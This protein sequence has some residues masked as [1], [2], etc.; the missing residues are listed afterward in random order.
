MGVEIRVVAKSP[1]ISWKT[2]WLIPVGFGGV[3]VILL[4]DTPWQ[5][6]AIRSGL[7]TAYSVVSHI[8][9]RICVGV[10]GFRVQEG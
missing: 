7:K 2:T 9:W 4:R 10:Q 5:K 1:V 8:I 3:T 6:I